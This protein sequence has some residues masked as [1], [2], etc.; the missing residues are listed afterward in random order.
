[1]IQSSSSIAHC[2]NIVL[3][4]QN[5]RKTVAWFMV[6]LVWLYVLC[7]SWPTLILSI[8]SRKYRCSC[9]SL[10]HISF[11]PGFVLIILLLWFRCY[12]ERT[13]CTI[14][15]YYKE[16]MR[17]Y[18]GRRVKNQPN[19]FHSLKLVQNQREFSAWI[20]NIF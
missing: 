5:I 6:Y 19:V 2:V 11:C 7:Y 15:F 9:K 16:M 18:K 3:L 8:Q 10:V 17:T 4:A 14:I 13:I 20:G 12:V 1:M